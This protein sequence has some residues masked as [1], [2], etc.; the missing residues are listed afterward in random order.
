MSVTGGNAGPL[1]GMRVIDATANVLGPIATQ[2]LGD[3]GADVVK[4][5][6]PFGDP[7]RGSGASRSPDMAA[8][9]MNM[10]R[11]KR[12]VVLDLKRPTA[13]E[14]LLRL[15]EG[16]D[17]FVHNMRQAAAGRL[18]IDYASLRARNPRIVYASASGYGSQGRHRDRPAFDDVIQGA[19]GVAG[20]N[21]R[22]QGTPRYA[23]MALA[24]KTAGLVFASAILLALLHRERTGEGQHVNVPMFETLVS[25]NLVEHLWNGVLDEPEAGLGYP[26]VLS[27]MRKPF[28]TTDGYI[29]IHAAS[30]EQWQRLLTVIGH[31][32]A[33][34]D[35]R[36]VDRRGRTENV[37]AL[38]GIV[39]DAMR[40]ATTREWAERLDAVD[41]PNSRASTLEDL[42]DDEYLTEIGFFQ[43]VTHPTEGKLVMM[44]NPIEFS[45]TPPALHRLPP[46]HGEHTAEVLAELGY[47]TEEIA[48][49]RG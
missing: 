28:G 27:P 10:N 9:F 33:A 38:Y 32:E 29:C 23:P 5:E 26:R 42:W 47:G 6:T 16:A 3:M 4:I 2:L 49:M 14:A 46:R 48:G 24:D 20:L 12:S 39:A 44:K 19:S 43:R 8:F 36:F 18:G 45:A 35:P 30:N 21:G 34:K 37:E 41:I 7:M 40:T 13:R 22:M 31:P 25:V 1:T 15:V 17:L 11:N